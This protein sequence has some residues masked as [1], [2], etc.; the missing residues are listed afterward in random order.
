MPSTDVNIPLIANSSGS[1][2]PPADMNV[3]NSSSQ[4]ISSNAN[5]SSNGLNMSFD[6]THKRPSV[7]SG[8]NL[9]IQNS[10]ANVNSQNNEAG[11]KAA[12]RRSEANETVFKISKGVKTFDFSFEKN[13]LITGGKCF[14]IPDEFLRS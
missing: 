7:L 8:T 4:Q 14:L 13:L 3:T 6:G 12:K 10:P 5:L 2:I 11:K 9:Q 1:N